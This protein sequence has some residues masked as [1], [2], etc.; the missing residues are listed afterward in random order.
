MC[1]IAGFWAQNSYFGDAVETLSA[2]GRM[3][4]HRGPD[5]QGQMWDDQ[6][7]LGLVHRRLAIQ[8]LSPAGAQPMVSSSGRFVIVFNGEIYNFRALSGELEAF[9]HYFRGHS[10]TEVMLAAFEQWGVE[11]ALKK[12]A[13]MFVFALWDKSESHLWLARDRMGEKPIYY[14]WNKGVL[15]FASELK[16]MRAFPGF[17]PE[18]DRD[19]LT[20]LLQHNYI[21]APHSIYRGIHKLLPAHYLCFNLK[22]G[23]S[24]PQSSAYWSLAETFISTE[25]WDM[26]S[27]AEELD[28]RLGEVIQEQMIAD[29]PL[30]AFLSGGI[31]SSS[32][33]AL[34][35]KHSNRTVR[36]FSIGFD[37]PGFNE[38][39]HA[40]AVANHLGTQH[41]ELYVTPHDALDVIPSLHEI[42][43]EPFADSSQIPTYLVCRMTKEHVTVAL[44]GD[45]GDEL[46][47]GYNHYPSTLAAW[48]QQHDSPGWKERLGSMLLGLPPEI[49]SPFVRTFIPGQRKLSKEG[50]KEKL[51]LQHDLRVAPDL[52]TFFA[53]C[54]G[55][56]VHPERL[57][58]GTVVPQY[59]LTQ[60]IPSS[61]A[62]LSGLKHLQWLDLNCYLPD[63][64][65]TKV[66]RAGM[67]VSLETRIPLLDH[68]IVSFALGLPDNLV[69]NGCIGKTVLRNVLYRYVPKELVDRPKQGFAI[70][71]SQWLR[72]ELRDWAEALLDES[73]MRQEG[74]WE[75]EPIRQAWTDHLDGREDNSF[76]LWGVLMFQAWLHK[77]IGG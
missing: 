49:I 33:V 56:W 11:E 66:D 73:R 48:H 7:R 8:D 69:R 24:H 59:A 29:V 35:Q 45:G 72:N 77:H 53:R 5:A 2:M 58:A 67:A 15:L 51:C 74:F 9:G 60:K 17:S 50:L 46:F 52:Q 12:F 4:A 43:D 30:G 65:L 14:G 34:M 10:D 76:K 25:K 1:G 22:Q 42:Y 41:T 31:D 63:D 38:A 13:G 54:N 75:V 32:V 44:S 64:I 28:R 71:V 70:P 68:R 39:V 3:I 18:I 40:A 21:P 36:T 61:L 19:A 27:A 62:H 20:L 57:V 16:A 47:A 6:L 55:Y 26:N 23:E 37:V